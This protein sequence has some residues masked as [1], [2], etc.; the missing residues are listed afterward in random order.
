[1]SLEFVNAEIDDAKKLANSIRDTLDSIASTHALYPELREEL[2][3]VEI[4][5]SDLENQAKNLRAG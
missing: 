2:R 5:L 1:M 4:V 3:L